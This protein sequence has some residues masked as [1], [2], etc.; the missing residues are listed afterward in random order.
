MN[1]LNRIAKSLALPLLFAALSVLITAILLGA[2]KLDRF[3]AIFTSKK[4]EELLSPLA[5]SAETSD[6]VAVFLANGQVYFGKLAKPEY[7]EPVLTEVFYLKIQ[8]GIQPDETD[9]SGDQA[10]VKKAQPKTDFKLIKLG[11]E[12]HGPIDQIKLNRDQILFWE[13]LRADS[14]VVEAIKAYQEQQSE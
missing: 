7:P 11:S 5:P 8:R 12:I 4:A 6:Y 3:T 9:N 10:D 14:K 2:I 1:G 13:K